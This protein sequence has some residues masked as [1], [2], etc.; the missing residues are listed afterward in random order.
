MPAQA[1]AT[2]ALADFGNAGTYIR[3]PAGKPASLDNARHCAG[4][5]SVDQLA[6]RRFLI[7][8]QYA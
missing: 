8:N 2:S 4:V 6:R 5:A 3:P 7:S 1:A